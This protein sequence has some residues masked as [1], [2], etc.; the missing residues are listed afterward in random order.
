MK[1]LGIETSSHSFSLCVNENDKVAYEITRNRQ[2]SVGR[3]ARFFAAAKELLD[4]Y[5]VENFQAIA[6]DIGPGMFTSLRVGLSLAKGFAF[7]HSIPIVAVNALDI[8]G[9]SMSFLPYQVLAVIN[10]YRGECYN[11]LYE[12]GKRKTDYLL[13]SLNEIKKTT[14]DKTIIMGSGSDVIEELCGVDTATKCS[15]HGFLQLT[16]SKVIS[17]ALPRIYE[18]KFDNVE[19]LEPY[20]IKKTD[21]ERHYNQ[22]NAV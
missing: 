9:L 1:I 4:Y 13:T 16:A 7:V 10:A 20:Y 15:Y 22:A 2:L 19:I 12:R 5:G 3:D 8:I 11:A 18:G 17:I 14:N 21:A 6:I